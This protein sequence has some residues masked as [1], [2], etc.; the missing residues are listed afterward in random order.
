MGA[1]E[2]LE[3][4]E[5]VAILMDCQM[6][7][8]DG[9]AA[10]RA[11]RRREHS[12]ELKS[13]NTIVALTA[14]ALPGDEQGCL[15][16]GMDAYLCKPFSMEDLHAALAPHMPDA[17]GARESVADESTVRPLLDQSVLDSLRKLQKRSNRNVIERILGTYLE[18]SP[19][20]LNALNTAVSSEDSEQIRF[21]AHGLKGAS[22]N[23]VAVRL[24]ELC[25]ELETQVRDHGASMA[26]RLLAGI[27]D[28]C[29][30]ICAALS[31]E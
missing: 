24:A 26:S 25:A 20:L 4:G 30:S 16:A 7:E 31:R 9:F 21:A 6:P 28:E 11:I 13:R 8:M 5:Y 18:R 3:H 19:V 29:R 2:A 23:V 12:G 1:L 15:E 10:T 22:A 14:D 17:S 27:D